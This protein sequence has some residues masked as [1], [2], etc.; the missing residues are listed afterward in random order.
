MI[1][2]LLSREGR[3]WIY[4]ILLAVVPLLVLYGVIDESA[5]PLWIAL[6]GAIVAPTLALSH[7]SPVDSGPVQE[8][9]AYEEAAMDDLTADG[10]A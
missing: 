9:P 3:K 10:D 7:L 6:L 4:S 1:D 5:A 2:R 8:I